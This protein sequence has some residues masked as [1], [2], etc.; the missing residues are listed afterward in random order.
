[1]HAAAGDR[2]EVGR[3]GRDER[4]A[5]SGLHLGDVA[6]VQGGAAHE[7]HVEVAEAERPARGLADGGERLRQQVVEGLAVRVA[8]AQLDGLVLQL[9]VAEVREVLFEGVDGLRVVLE[10][11]D[12]PPL[13]DA[14]DLFEDRGHGVLQKVEDRSRA[15]ERGPRPA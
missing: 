5:L 4:L 1:M 15:P 8:L 13:P 3:E 10:A 6:Q 14:K 11:A 9:L 12:D 7:L 2:V